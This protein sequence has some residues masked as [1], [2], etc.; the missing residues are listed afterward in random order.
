MTKA[1]LARFL[2]KKDMNYLLRRVGMIGVKSR[3]GASLG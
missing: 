1:C 3:F 2:L